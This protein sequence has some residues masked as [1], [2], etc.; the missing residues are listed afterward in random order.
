LKPVF[1]IHGPN[2]NLLGE[3]EPEHYGCTTLEELNSLLERQARECGLNLAFFQSNHEGDLVDQLHRAREAA[4]G[5]IINPG[6][7]TH[8]GLSLRDAAAAV[9]LPIVEVHLSNIHAREEFRKRSVLAPVCVG[10]ISG[11]GI[12]SYLLA[13][14]WMAGELLGQGGSA[15]VDFDQ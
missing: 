3:R 14:Q 12:H 7:L 11:F 8:Y 13:L 15:T 5:V 6:A 9:E 10:Q 4:A 2:L 1:V